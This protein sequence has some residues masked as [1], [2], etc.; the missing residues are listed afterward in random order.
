MPADDGWSS[1]AVDWSALWGRLADPA[2]DAVV[3]ATSIGPATRVLDVGCGSGEFLALVERAGGHPSGIDPAPGMLALARAA[4]P[5]ADVRQGRAE[6][7]PWPDASFDVVT[8]FN[9]L[10]FADDTVEALGELMRVTVPGGYVA[11]AN[12]AERERNDIDAIEAA[13]VE[14]DGEEPTPDGDLRPAGGLESLFEEAG[15]PLVSA[16]LVDVVWAVADDDAL[17][18]GALLGEDEA[19]RASLAPVVLAAA[20]PFRDDGGYRLRNA[21]RLAIGR[22]PLR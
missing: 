2:R 20:R 10:Q 6:R 12:W 1:V 8:A 21:F 18:R 9:A 4:V 16:G 5:A 11:V 14:A 22:L 15:L 7:L 19:V 17:V 13:V 3:A